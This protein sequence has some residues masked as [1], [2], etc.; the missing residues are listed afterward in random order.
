MK[1]ADVEEKRD[2]LKKEEQRL[3]D[4]KFAHEQQTKAYKETSGTLYDDLDGVY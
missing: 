2:I 3:A 4:L 1:N